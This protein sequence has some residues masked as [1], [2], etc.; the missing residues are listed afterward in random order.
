MKY[1]CPV[2]Q[3]EDHTDNAQ[4]C[5]ICGTKIVDR[6]M[7]TTFPVQTINV[8]LEEYFKNR[9]LVLTDNPTYEI[10]YTTRSVGIGPSEHD[11]VKTKLKGV[12]VKIKNNIKAEEVKVAQSSRKR[13]V[14]KQIFICTKR[15]KEDA[16]YCR[17]C[18]RKSPS[19]GCYM[20]PIS[21]TDSTCNG[22]I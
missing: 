8:A 14:V 15:N 3:N 1:T 6:I 22:G 19:T 4:F 7:S 18:C 11:E 9:G 12:T 10:E 5:K 16:S 17:K 20:C 21:C 13:S 2:C